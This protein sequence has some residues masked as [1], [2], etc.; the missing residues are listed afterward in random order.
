MGNYKALCELL[1]CLIFQ[2]PADMQ[3]FCI[4]HGL[5]AYECEPLWRDET[6]YL[7][8]SPLPAFGSEN[9]VQWHAC[10]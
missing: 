9:G 3:V 8:G 10:S 7:C 4:L 2:I 5:V 6:D 1:K